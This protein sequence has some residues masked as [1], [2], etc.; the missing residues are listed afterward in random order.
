MRGL[1]LRIGAEHAGQ[2]F[3]W[4]SVDEAGND[5]KVLLSYIAEALYAV[6]PI[7]GRVFDALA[8]PVSTTPG[9]ETPRPS[10]AGSNAELHADR[11]GRPEVQPVHVTALCSPTRA[12]LLTGRNSHTVGVGSV[13]EFAGGFPGQS[14]KSP[15]GSPVTARP[16]T[17]AGARA[18]QRCSGCLGTDA[19][20]RRVPRPDNG[21]PDSAWPLFVVP[22]GR[23]RAGGAGQPDGRWAV[24]SRWGPIPISSGTR[25]RAAAVSMTTR[26][27]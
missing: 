10:G 21:C 16:F 13:G 26:R 17:S 20:D 23:V 15:V 12:A 22:R 9:S 24:A 25:S 5:P 27:S 4:V 7:D 14:A 8:S 6:E 11:R 1:W 18:G 19:G 2:A 3:A